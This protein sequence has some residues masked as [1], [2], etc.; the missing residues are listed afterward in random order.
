MITSVQRL[1]YDQ[2]R[3]EDGGVKGVQG[4]EGEA[5]GEEV[6]WNRRGRGS[7]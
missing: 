7:F 4:Q 6:G 5:M 2:M 3:V 1:Q